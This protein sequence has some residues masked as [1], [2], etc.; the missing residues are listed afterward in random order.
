ML[1]RI[2]ERLRA[3]W[4]LALNE[5]ATPREIGL[6]VGLG[7]AVGCTPLIGLHG[8]IAVGLATIFR[9]SRLWTFMGSRNANF[10][11]IPWIALAEVQLAHRVRTGEWAP[12]SV[13]TA[14]DHAK[15]LLL[16]WCLGMIPIAIVVGGLLGSLAFAIARARLARIAKRAANDEDQRTT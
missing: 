11:T 1:Q 16:D 9:L 14:V 13:D 3:L 10:I 12:L 8:W 7:A 4:I 5:R 15:E 6:A 2:F